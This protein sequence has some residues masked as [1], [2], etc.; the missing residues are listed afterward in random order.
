MVNHSN[1]NWWIWKV[2]WILLIVTAIEV[3]LGIIKPPFMMEVYFGTKLIN[4]IFIMLTLI[5]AAYIV[6]EFMH[7]GQ[8]KK[9]LKLVIL[10][11][12]L[13]LIPY[14]LFILLTEGLYAS[15]MI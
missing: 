1:S 4:H 6:M 7:L 13:I 9:G 8:E 15:I 12:A 10:L 2:F 3:A 11:P 5:K 14:M